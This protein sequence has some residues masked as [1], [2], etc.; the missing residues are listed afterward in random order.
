MSLCHRKCDIHSRI[1]SKRFKIDTNFRLSNV[2][3]HVLLF[4]GFNLRQSKLKVFLSLPRKQY[5]GLFLVISSWEALAAFLWLSFRLF[6][7][8]FLPL[9][10]KRPIHWNIVTIESLLS[11]ESLFLLFSLTSVRFVIYTSDNV[12]PDFQK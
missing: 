10:L 7:P 3:V 11:L 6:V 4:K 2:R 8:L 12:S 9:S 1:N 5:R